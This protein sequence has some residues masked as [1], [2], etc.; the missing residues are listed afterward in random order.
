M[1]DHEPRNGGSG[2]LGRRDYGLALA[3]VLVATLVLLPGLFFGL[4]GKGVA[5]AVRILHGEVPYRD[6]WTMYAPGMFY[7]TAGVFRIFGIELLAQGAVSL[8]LD[9]CL[10]GVAFLLFR[11]MARGRTVALVLALV[12][13]GAFWKTGREIT[14][15]PPAL[16]FLLLFWHGLIGYWEHGGPRRLLYAGL[17]VGLAACFKHD[18]AAYAVLAAVA[19]LFSTWHLAA[20]RRPPP[21]SHPLVATL[22][23]AAGALATLL[24]LA[25]WIAWQAGADA[26]QD[27]FV[28]PAVTFRKVMVPYYPPL[29]PP[30]GS[31]WSLLQEFS[32]QKARGSVEA[33]SEWLLC[34]VPQ[35]VFVVAVVVV[36]RLWRR[37]A[38]ATL[39]TVLMLLAAL[40][41]FWSAAHIQQNTHVTSM[42][43]I[44][45][46]FAAMSWAGL[47][48]PDSRVRWARRWIV[49][50][51][52][53]VAAGLWL[54]AAMN[55]YEMRLQ[56][57]EGQVLDVPGA[58]SIHVPPR[59]YAA[60]PPIIDFLQANTE[61][62]ERIYVGLARHDAI[63]INDWSLHVLARRRSCSRYSELHRGVV[64]VPE[65]QREIIR[66]LE[67]HRVRA[68]VLW[69]FGWPDAVLDRRLALHRANL[70]ELGSTLLDEYIA[71]HYDLLAQHGE[72]L[73]MWRKGIPKPAH[74]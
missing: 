8:L 29:L 25:A 59:V 31:F 62:D 71:E 1:T 60:Y 42:A 36:V 9:A 68:V 47:R 16:L 38:P 37:L 18:V 48:G 73:L 66:D 19:S 53:L 55:M 41:F 11:R 23:L 14:S 13:L 33:L 65:G 46:S 56:W 43:L 10:V 24:P 50:G 45:L 21:W 49:A 61:E 67:R 39:A 57:R 34:N 4:P 32:M 52:A 72:Y 26:W 69:K 51:C 35:Y 44:G 2:L 74:G 15:Y 40:P 20:D 30:F 27:L 70:P 5:G 64:D 54:Q 12:F 58:R 22:V 7:A 6:F 3:L 17:C 28:F 63:V